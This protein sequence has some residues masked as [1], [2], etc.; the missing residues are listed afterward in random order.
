MESGIDGQGRKVHYKNALKG[1]AYFCPY[2]TELLNLRIG[3]KSYFAHKAIKERTPLQRTCPEY[4]ENMSYKKIDNAADIVYINNGGIP[5][6]LCNDGSKFELRAYFPSISETCKNSLVKNQTEVII[7]NKKWC[8]VENLNYYPVYDIKNWIYIDVSPSTYFNEVK[9]KWLLGIRGINIE[10]DMYHANNEGG[11]RVALKSNIYIGKKYRIMFSKNIPYV[12]GITFKNIGKLRL[13]QADREKLLNIYDMEITKF[14]EEARQFVEGKGYHLVEKISK[15]I[16]LWPPAIFKGN[17]LIFD[18]DIAWFYHSPNSRNEYFYEIQE[19]RIYKLMGN[20]IFKISN[21]SICR[22]KAIVIT[23]KLVHYQ[24][25]V[26][27]GAEIKY[28]INY[29]K[30]L[31]DKKLLE[32]KVIIKDIEGQLI[33][34]RQTNNSIP[35]AGKIFIDSNVPLI[36]RITKDSYCLYSSKYSLDEITYGKA[37]NIDCKGFGNIF[38]KYEKAYNDSEKTNQLDWKE[39]YEEFCKCR[40]TT[41]SPTYRNKMLLYKIRKNI[42]KENRNFYEILYKC[43]QKKEVP[44]GLQR[45]L[46]E[47]ER[48]ICID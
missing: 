35:K 30:K 46:D 36:S 42:N 19:D 26:G 48:E 14:T 29:R 45:L 7:N 23:N 18:K 44:I 20:K 1:K 8:C 2:C 3:K 37:I 47:I 24:Q 27:I 32:P 34:Y 22:E 12:S 25:I 16:P 40:G 38:Y 9:R 43:I 15:V 13:K 17:E 5:L 33:D 6:Y 11:Y 31:N 39:L 4:H 28:I 10:Q 21:I 41:V